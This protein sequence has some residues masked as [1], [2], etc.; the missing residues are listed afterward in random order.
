MPC[1]CTVSGARNSGQ[2]IQLG[3]RVIAR[4][5]KET[6]PVFSS[7][8]IIN[9]WGIKHVRKALDY[10]LWPTVQNNVSRKGERLSAKKKKK[11]KKKIY[12]QYNAASP[13]LKE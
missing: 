7:N 13:P 12:I 3:Y 4:L 5:R 10:R 6:L 2:C 9:F 8:S 11:K 1:V